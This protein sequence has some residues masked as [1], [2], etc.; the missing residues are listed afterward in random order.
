[1]TRP[2][3]RGRRAALRWGC[4][5]CLAWAGLQGGTA[6]HAQ[7][8]AAAPELPAISQERLG[9]PALD[10]DEGGLWAMLDREE[11]RLRRSPLV[12][13]DAALTQWLQE[14]TC[15]LAGPHCP[16][17]RVHVVRTPWFNASMA[18]NGMMQVWT[19]LLLRVENEAQLA[20]V[21]GHELGHYL[22]R[23]TLERLRD[24]RGKAA[25][26]QFASMFGL[27]GAIA[28]MGAMAGAFAFGREQETRADAIGL[29]L[30]M[31]AGFDGRQA[32]QVWENLLGELKVRGGEEAGKRSPM[33]ASHP[34]PAGRR[35]ELLRLAGSRG[36]ELGQQT[37]DRLLAPH[38]LGWLQDE[39][40]RGQYE[41]SLV[42]FGRLMEQRPQDPELLWARAEIWRLR[43][44]EGDLDR[45]L[46]DLR[47]CT[48]SAQPPADA[49]RSLGHVLRQRSD[50]PGAA[51]AFRQYLAASPSA[52]DAGLIQSYLSELPQ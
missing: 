26:A 16:D 49:F 47:A 15:R 34:P 36:G 50:G 32:A 2:A 22:E 48:A 4:A 46:A 20:A 21:L 45:A 44:G 28:G 29:R 41:E 31:D 8:P 42:L 1:M 52:G 10:T 25:F 51:Q 37:L 17:V 14:L 19:G 40:R 24:V 7:V 13:R 39:I 35:D 27:I 12:V 33:M 30:M 9:R 3:D 43:A 23:H 11:T 18:P 5:H 38:R 6:A